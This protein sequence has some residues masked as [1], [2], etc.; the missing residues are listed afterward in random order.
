MLQS[1][2]TIGKQLFPTKKFMVKQLIKKNKKVETIYF[3]WAFH[4]YFIT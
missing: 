4:H 2:Y 1:Y 3:Q